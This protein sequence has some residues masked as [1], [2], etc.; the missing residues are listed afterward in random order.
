MS[1]DLIKVIRK[2]ESIGLYKEARL[3]K[4]AI[5]EDIVTEDTGQTVWLAQS[6]YREGVETQ[7]YFDSEEDAQAWLDYENRDKHYPGLY[8]DPVS[9]QRLVR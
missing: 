1:K 6:A 9:V 4:S 7:H 5:L 8:I 2:L 3:I